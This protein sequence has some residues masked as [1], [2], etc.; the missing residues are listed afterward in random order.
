MSGSRWLTLRLAQKLLQ[1]SFRAFGYYRDSGLHSS[2]HLVFCIVSLLW[3]MCQLEFSQ[4][5]FKAESNL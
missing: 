3:W 2:A 1:S 5:A 4:S